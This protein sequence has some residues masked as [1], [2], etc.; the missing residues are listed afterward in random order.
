M[1]A[2]VPLYDVEAF[3]AAPLHRDPFDFLVVPGFIEPDVLSELNRDFPSIQ[4]PGN[5]P[6]EEL[7]YGPTFQALLDQLNEPALSERNSQK[8]GVELA[9]SP[10]TITL[11][12]Y[13]EA[14][15]GNIHTDHWSKIITMLIYF[16]TDWD[17][18]GGR[19]RLLRS[20]DDLED[21]AMEAPPLGGTL[22]AFRRT[23]NSFHGHEQFVGERRML[24][25]S[26]VRPN[27]MAQFMQRA[28]R[29]STRVM[30]RLARLVQTDGRSTRPA[31][32]SRTP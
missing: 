25:M 13:C 31:R 3:D 14:S 19:L 24:Q 29:F 2:T 20:A 8:F 32:R 12:K 28:D 16:N 4:T 11:R 10:T 1:M 18:P 6:P 5:Y 23:D 22:I 21:Y 27:R 9:H 15:D 30:K 26:W 17:H 7:T